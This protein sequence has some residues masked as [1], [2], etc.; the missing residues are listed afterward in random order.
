MYLYNQI[1]PKI[2]QFPEIHSKNAEK[3][4]DHFKIA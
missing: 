4:K 2:A 3:P 1:I